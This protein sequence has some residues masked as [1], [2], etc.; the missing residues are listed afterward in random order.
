MST[1]TARRVN[2]TFS[3]ITE[4]ER[5]LREERWPYKEVA[6][7]FGVNRQALSHQIPGYGL[8]RKELGVLGNAVRRANAKA[9]KRG[10]YV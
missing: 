5:L 1:S 7:K 3:Q 6:L 10:E 4:A 2:L 9:R 8:T